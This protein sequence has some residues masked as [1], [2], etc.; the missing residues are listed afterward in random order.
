M[1]MVEKRDA[2]LA[3]LAKADTLEEIIIVGWR[4]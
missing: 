3:K 2:L 4:L 1:N